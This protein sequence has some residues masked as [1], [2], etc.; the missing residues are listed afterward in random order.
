MCFNVPLSY[1]LWKIRQKHWEKKILFSLT[2]FVL[3][4]YN[5]KIVQYVVIKCIHFEK[6]K[7]SDNF[8]K[9]RIWKLKTICKYLANVA[10]LKL[11]EK[12]LERK[13]T[14]TLNMSL[15]YKILCSTLCEFCDVFWCRINLETIMSGWIKLLGLTGYTSQMLKQGVNLVYVFKMIRTNYLKF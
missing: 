9:K 10:K 6:T 14:E 13:Q 3:R 5:K 7:T 11:R 1:I 15:S 12:H 4:P 8:Y 2:G